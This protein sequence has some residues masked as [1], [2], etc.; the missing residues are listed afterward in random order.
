MTGMF[1][2]SRTKSNPGICLILSINFAKSVIVP[3]IPSDKVPKSFARFSTLWS[4]L[5]IVN[6]SKF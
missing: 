3:A 2:G 5:K 4:L 6:I 1:E